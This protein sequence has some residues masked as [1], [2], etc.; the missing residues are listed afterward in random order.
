MAGLLPQC[1]VIEA[2]IKSANSKNAEL[3]VCEDMKSFSENDMV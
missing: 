3:E 1:S 2:V